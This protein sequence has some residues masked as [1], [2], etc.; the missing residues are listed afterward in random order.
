M[1]QIVHPDDDDHHAPP[2]PHKVQVPT[3]G[4]D[5]PVFDVDDES[6][7]RHSD[8]LSRTEEGDMHMPLPNTPFYFHRGSNAS[9]FEFD[10]ECASLFSRRGS[11]S[12]ELEV[13]GNM[14]LRLPRRGS[15]GQQLSSRS[16]LTVPSWKRKFTV[17]L[18]VQ[19]SYS[20]AS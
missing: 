20:K 11:Y 13:S 8:D 3:I 19:G 18:E 10:P 12:S 16:N 9:M 4:I 1:T 5:N 17:T 2:S 6:R 14:S 7:S 15:Y